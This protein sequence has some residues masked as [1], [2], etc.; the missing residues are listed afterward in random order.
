MGLTQVLH[1]DRAL[2]VP[3]KRP[4]GL[5]TALWV[6]IYRVIRAII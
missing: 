5:L 1:A 2:Q 3:A 6:V 4:A